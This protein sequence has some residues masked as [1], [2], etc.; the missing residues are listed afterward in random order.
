MSLGY[1]PADAL[2]SA[3][4]LLAKAGWVLGQRWD[5]EV[6]LPAGFEY[7]LSEGPRQSPAAWGALDVRPADP[8]GWSAADAA[9][10]AQLIL[11]SGAAGPAFLVFDNHFVI[12]KY[13]N[14]TAYALSVG[15]L[16]DRIAG[17]G[18]LVTPWPHEDALALS[19][20]IAAQSALA[21]LG[22]DPGAPDGVI[23]AGT[24]AAPCAAGRRLRAC[25]QMAICRCR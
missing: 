20:R 13:N 24:R 14:S 9:G 2:A 10:Q 18:P 19:D 11:P 5:R 23:G 16:A 12:R 8:G 7:S 3:A 17:A 1:S 4:N 21:K 15:L 6:I 22:Y 25:R